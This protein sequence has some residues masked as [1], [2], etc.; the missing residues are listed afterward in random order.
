MMKVMQRAAKRI[1]KKLQV[2]K[3]TTLNKKVDSKKN[4]NIKKVPSHVLADV[5]LGEGRWSGLVPSF[6]RGNL[7]RSSGSENKKH[8]KNCETALWAKKGVIE[9]K[10]LLK[11]LL[12]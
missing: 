1:W 7:D 11:E 5:E 12:Y 9:R 10:A 2:R 8:R 3:L 6:A 4:E